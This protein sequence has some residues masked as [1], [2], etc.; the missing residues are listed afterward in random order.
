MSLISRWSEAVPASLL[1]HRLHFRKKQPPIMSFFE[2]FICL[3]QDTSVINWNVL[4]KSEL[5]SLDCLLGRKIIKRSSRSGT[6]AGMCEKHE[7]HENRLRHFLRKATNQETL[8]FLKK[9]Y[10]CS[11]K[12]QTT[13]TN[14]TQHRIKYCY[15]SYWA[16]YIKKK[17][18]STYIATFSES[19]M[20]W[21]YLNFGS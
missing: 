1:P 17:A 18:S 5:F 11:Q 7:I 8:D 12:C 13:Q 6:N 4:S 14:K 19:W 16:T 20:V 2:C 15:S 3:W 9:A 10:S 21:L